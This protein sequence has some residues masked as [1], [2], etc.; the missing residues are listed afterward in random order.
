MKRL[1]GFY[2]LVPGLTLY[3]CSLLAMFNKKP[4]AVILIPLAFLL[5]SI[6]NRYAPLFKHKYNIYYL[7]LPVFLA[8]I[9]MR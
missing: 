1:I 9:F 5:I 3:I 7:C 8:F 4:A 6:G 2:M